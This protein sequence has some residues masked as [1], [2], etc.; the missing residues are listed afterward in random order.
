[1]FNDNVNTL[2]NKNLHA[3][4]SSYLLKKNLI[5]KGNYREI[6]LCAHFKLEEVVYIKY[7]YIG[8]QE[9]CIL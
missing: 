6:S 3:I 8:H 5:K 1:M 4:F 2:W 9:S 7:T